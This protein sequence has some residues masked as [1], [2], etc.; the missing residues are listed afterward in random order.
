M[1]SRP[2]LA[3]SSDAE[4][5]ATA[6][7]THAAVVAERDQLRAQLARIDQVVERLIT[8]TRPVPAGQLLT[9]AEQQVVDTYRRLS[10]PQKAALSVLLKGLA[11]DKGGTR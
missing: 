1:S 6:A 7:Q 4:R 5:I 10:G 8:S 11:G 2:H 9:P 3:T